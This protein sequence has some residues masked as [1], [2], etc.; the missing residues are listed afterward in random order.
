M[1]FVIERPYIILEKERGEQKHHDLKEV[2]EA[3]RFDLDPVMELC[4]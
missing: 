3:H 2:S 1:E 4:K